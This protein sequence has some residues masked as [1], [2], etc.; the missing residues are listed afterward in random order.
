[1]SFVFS[2]VGSGCFR[3]VAARLVRLQA[4]V[5]GF[6]YVKKRFFLTQPFICGDVSDGAVCRARAVL[7]L[8]C[9]GEGGRVGLGRKYLGRDDG[10]A[11]AA[12]GA[13]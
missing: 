13:R 11:A 3:W 7:V 10:T 6:F 12:L 5:A 1:M 8:V 9:R 4:P 2:L